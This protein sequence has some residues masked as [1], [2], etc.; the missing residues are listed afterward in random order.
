MDGKEELYQDGG[1]K[2]ILPVDTILGELHK[3]VGAVER[4][5]I[6]SGTVPVKTGFVFGTQFRG[7]MV[8]PVLN[9]TLSFQYS[10]HEI[11]EEER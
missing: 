7:E 2:D 8:D 3:R 11:G 9:R 6:F 5:V 4:S 1:L 10:V